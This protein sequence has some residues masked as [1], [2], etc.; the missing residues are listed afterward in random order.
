MRRMES[1]GWKLEGKRVWVESF[2]QFPMIDP[3]SGASEEVMTMNLF[4]ISSAM[5]VSL[6]EFVTEIEQIHN[7]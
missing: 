2:A 5:N 1:F 7:Q 3:Y 4:R 6:G